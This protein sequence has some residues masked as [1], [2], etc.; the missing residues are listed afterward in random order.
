MI[1][2]VLG[3]LAGLNPFE[4]FIVQS[5]VELSKMIGD[6]FKEVKEERKQEKNNR[7]F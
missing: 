5:L 7:F 4:G 1:V 3:T 6:V 2:E